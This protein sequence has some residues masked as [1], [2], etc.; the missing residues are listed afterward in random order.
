MSTVFDAWVI[1]TQSVYGHGLIGR[2]YFTR[3][4]GLVPVHMDGCRCA[5]FSTRKIA[6]EHL[7]QVKR[8]FPKAKVIRVKV[9]VTS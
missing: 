3:V 2:Y 1:D 7:Q 6:R 8:S 5:M 4:N 9:K